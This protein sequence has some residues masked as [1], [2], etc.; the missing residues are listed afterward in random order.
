MKPLVIE[1]VHKNFGGLKAANNINLVVDL[2]E[3]RAIIG[4]NGAGKTT[5][6]NIISGT[7]IPSSG[8]VNIFGN[9]VTSLPPHK[10]V[11]LGLGRT[12][13][14]TNLFSNLTVMENLLLALKSVERKRHFVLRPLLSCRA[15]CTHAEILMEQS[16]MWEKRHAAVHTL[17]YGEQRR[18]EVLMALAQKPKLLLLD[19]FSSGLSLEET[20]TLTSM[21][22]SLQRDI[23]I[24]LIEHDMDVAFEL[25]ERFTVLHLG[26]VFAEGDRNEI[27]S[28]ARVQQIYFGEDE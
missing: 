8:R 26:S 19:E 16:G 27:R 23:T 24:V 10:R 21:L 22:K 4:P 15:M 14:I 25:A 1:K 11:P 2:G 9:D 3:R 20:T 28:N 18:V 13:Q 7:L 12:F 6:F 17:S 5:L